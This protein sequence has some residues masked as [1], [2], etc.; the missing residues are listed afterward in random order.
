MVKQSK[1]FCSLSSGVVHVLH[2]FGDKFH[3]PKNGLIK[4]TKLLFQTTDISYRSWL[5]IQTIVPL[6]CVKKGMLSRQEVIGTKRQGDAP[7]EDLRG[8]L[9]WCHHPSTQEQVPLENMLHSIA[10]HAIDQANAWR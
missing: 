9:F 10:V 5:F 8:S 1:V 4:A 3:R 6:D 7:S 2:V